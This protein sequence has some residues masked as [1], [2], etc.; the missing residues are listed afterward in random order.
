MY[1][2]SALLTPLPFILFTTE[3]ITGCTNECFFI[4]SFT[5][6]VTPPINTPKYSNYFMILIISFISSFKI[7]K[8]NLFSA[9]TARFPLISLSNLF[10]AF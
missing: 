7:N 9:L 3:E 10:V 2:L 4:S 8:L 6:L 5:V 1:P